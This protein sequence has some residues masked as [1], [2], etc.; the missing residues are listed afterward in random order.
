MLYKDHRS[1]RSAISLGLALLAVLALAGCQP[2]APPAPTQGGGATGAKPA[3]KHKIAGIVFQDDQFFKLAESGM[4]AE[5]AKEGVDVATGNS[6]NALD[7]EIT[8][9]DTYTS[10]KV[11]AIVIAPVSTKGS[12]P[13]LKRANDAGI[14]I[15][16][17]DRAI[18]ADFPAAIIQ[19]DPA[20]LGKLTGVEAARYIQEKRGGKANIAILTYMA[21]APETAS[22]R[23]KGFTDEVTKLPGVK[24]V[25]QQDAWLAPEAATQAE[26]ILTAHPEVD[27]IWAANEGGTVGAV[28]AVR[29]GGKAGKVVVFGTDISEQMAD[30]LMAD[31]NILQAVTGQRPFDIGSMAVAAAVKSVNGEPVRKMTALDGILYTRTKPDE[32]KK[33]K[34]YLH[35]VSK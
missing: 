35:G 29:S 7:K 12:V 23:T 20:S 15:V 3:G 8:L 14:K 26:T 22:R 1:C 6:G 28:T 34:E 31:D 18:E 9:V 19:T 5:A 27:M 21:L 13:A 25:T 33:V 10:Q 11:D 2:P 32:V 30:F 4:K 17:Y 16:T 24:I